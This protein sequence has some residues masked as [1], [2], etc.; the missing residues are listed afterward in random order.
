MHKTL[1]YNN[2][3]NADLRSTKTKIGKQLYMFI[4]L[5]RTGLDHAIKL[6]KLYKYMCIINVSFSFVVVRDTFKSSPIIFDFHSHFQM[7]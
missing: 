2:E 4:D 1:I 3:E 7:N 6:T 5:L